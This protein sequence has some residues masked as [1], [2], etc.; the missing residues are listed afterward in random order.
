MP[1]AGVFIAMTA[2][3]LIAKIISQNE[4][5]ELGSDSNSGQFCHRSAAF[6]IEIGL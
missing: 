5:K 3:L 1:L 4:A 2:I 6:H